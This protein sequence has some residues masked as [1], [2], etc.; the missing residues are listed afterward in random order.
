MA[1]LQSA[2]HGGRQA[3]MGRCVFAKKRQSF[4][5]V[6]VKNIASETEIR[7]HRIVNAPFMPFWLL[8]AAASGMMDISA[9]AR[10][11]N[12]GKGAPGVELSFRAR[13]SRTAGA[14]AALLLATQVGAVLC[15]ALLR[16]VWPQLVQSGWGV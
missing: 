9:R 11:A 3:A 13:V 8:R 7:V 4:R 15:A 16:A 2:P 6:D 1:Q 10:R 14:Y 12:Q 5:R